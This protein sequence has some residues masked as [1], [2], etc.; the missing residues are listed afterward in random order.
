MA[1]SS[2]MKRCGFS[3]LGGAGNPNCH[4][5]TVSPAL[6]PDFGFSHGSELR[7]AFPS[8]QEKTVLASD[9]VRFDGFPSPRDEFPRSDGFQGQAHLMDSTQS[10]DKVRDLRSIFRISEN[11]ER[12]RE[13]DSGVQIV[14]ASRSPSELS[15]HQMGLSLAG[16]SRYGGRAYSFYPWYFSPCH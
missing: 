4:F 1:G 12:L 8:S 7:D 3:P 16:A 13:S 15:A 5:S 9:P 2:S 14:P 6:D 11:S 10:R